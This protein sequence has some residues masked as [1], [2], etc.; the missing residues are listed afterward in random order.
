VSDDIDDIPARMQAYFLYQQR[1]ARWKAR[2]FYI[3]QWERRR[4]HE[5]QQAAERFRSGMG[6][7]SFQGQGRTPHTLRLSRGLIKAAQRCNMPRE[8]DWPT[9]AWVP[10][11][12]R[13]GESLV[14]TPVPAATP[15]ADL[16]AMRALL[17]DICADSDAQVAAHNAKRNAAGEALYQ[18][19]KAFLGA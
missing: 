13:N 17:R 9:N 12:V 18:R 2:E 6:A 14:R 8:G 4:L 5:T 10:F 3:E 19:A 11:R 1:E 16:V 7:V 15:P